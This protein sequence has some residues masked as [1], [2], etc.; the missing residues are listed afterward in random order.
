MRHRVTSGLP[1][2]EPRIC[3]RCAECGG[4]LRVTAQ[5]EALCPRCGP[6]R[7][8]TVSVGDLTGEIEETAAGAL[9]GLEDLADRGRARRRQD[10]A[11]DRMAYE[12]E[13]DG[14][15]IYCSSFAAASVLL[16]MGW[17]LNRSGQWSRLAQKLLDARFSP[18]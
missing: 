10:A 3:R 9:A 7:A 18:V 16:A 1:H 12:L 6:V 5:H 13:R 2:P 8:W 4:V 14:R 15:A 17:R 11:V